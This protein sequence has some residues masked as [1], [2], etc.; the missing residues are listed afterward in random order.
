MLSN[1]GRMVAALTMI[2]G[3]VERRLRG[4][5]MSANS[6]VQHLASGIGASIGGLILVKST[7]G[8]IRNFGWVGI[9]AAAATVLS[10]WLAG[11]V[12]PAEET[13]GP[14]TMESTRDDPAR[15]VVAEAH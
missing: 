7:D 12:R 11:R 6:A 3:S 2:T 14:E 9:L 8:T 5:F 13:I 4:G 10:L 1:A 15:S